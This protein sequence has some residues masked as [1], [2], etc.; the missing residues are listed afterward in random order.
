MAVG[1]EKTAHVAQKRP[2]IELTTLSAP[3]PSQKPLSHLTC[4]NDFQSF[5]SSS[6][7]TSGNFPYR[8]TY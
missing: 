7:S 2:R 6:S 8:R 4:D 1:K 5:I 3:S